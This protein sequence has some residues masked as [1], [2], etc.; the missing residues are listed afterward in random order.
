MDN[1][2]QNNLRQCGK[3]NVLEF[4]AKDL[5]DIVYHIGI[6]AQNNKIED[7][8]FLYFVERIWNVKNTMEIYA[9]DE[10]VHIVSL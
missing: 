5:D 1:Q 4:L 6:W 8:N 10:N 9:K 2:D 7:D 3:H